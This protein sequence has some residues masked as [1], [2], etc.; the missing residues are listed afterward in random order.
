MHKYIFPG[1]SVGEVKPLRG[2]GRREV[3]HGNLAERANISRGTLLLI[4]RGETE[5]SGKT[6]LNIAKAL[7]HQVEEIFLPDL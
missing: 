6:M 1:F 7:G 2:P 4:E 3:G 5:P